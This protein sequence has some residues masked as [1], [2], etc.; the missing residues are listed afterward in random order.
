[1][2]F[3]SINEEKREREKERETAI[4]AKSDRYARERGS[5]EM[6]EEQAGVETADKVFK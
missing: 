1:M 4:M 3:S 5:R 2:L 6:R